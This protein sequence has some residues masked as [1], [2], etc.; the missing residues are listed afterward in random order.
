MKPR[1]RLVV[2]VAGL[3]LVM[4]ATPTWG[5]PV[6]VAPGCNPTVSDEDGSTAGRTNALTNNLPG[7]TGGTGNTA[8]GK[9]ALFRNTNG[10]QNTDR[11][12]RARQQHY[13]HRQH[14]DRPWGARQQHRRQRQL[15]LRRSRTTPRAAPTPPAATRPSSITP[16]AA[17]TRPVAPVPCS[18]TAQASAIRQSG[19][20]PSRR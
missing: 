11:S 5:Q 3:V 15:R 13:R 20:R 1:S 6:C 19:M 8:F 4:H 12:Q 10:F 7:R 17:R 18:P 9:W 16:P 14:G 2:L